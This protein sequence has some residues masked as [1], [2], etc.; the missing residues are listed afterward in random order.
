M[1]IEASGWELFSQLKSIFLHVDQ[2]ERTFLS[3]FN[4]TPSRFSILIHT[5]N[6]PGINYIDLS[7]LLLCT[8]SNTTRIVKAMQ[9]EGLVKRKENR[10]DRRSYHLE[11]TEKGKLLHKEVHSAYLDHINQLLENLS[12]DQLLSYINMSAQLGEVLEPIRHA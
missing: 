5:H 3:R 12:E 7:D 1:T 4:L 2:Q 8:R 9:M 10:E 11:L 6:F